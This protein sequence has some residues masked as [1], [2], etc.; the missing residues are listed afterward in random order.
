MRKYHV[1]QIENTRTQKATEVFEMD[2]IARFKMFCQLR[3][4]IRG[5]GDHL[6]V[7]IDIAKDR[8]H[9]FFGTGMLVMR[10]DHLSVQVIGGIQEPGRFLCGV[11]FGKH[12]FSAPGGMPCTI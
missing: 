3:R 8:H 1:K 10:G 2:D 6:I 5:S 12:T 4:Q 7:G 9:A 11:T